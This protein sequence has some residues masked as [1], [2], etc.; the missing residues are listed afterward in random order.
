MAKKGSKSTGLL[1]YIFAALILVGFI[2]VIVGMFVGQVTMTASSKL[3]GGA[4]SK[5]YMLFDGDAWGVTEVAG[6]EIGVS[7]TFGI[8]SFI[9]A[10]IGAL[11]LVCDAVLNVFL[12][13]NFKIVRFVGIVLTFVGA[14]LV[15]VAGLVMANQCGEHLSVDLGNLAQVDYSAGAGVWLGFI[16]GLVAAIASGLSTVF[17]K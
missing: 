14:I 6:K 16:G 8:I 4:E 5:T 7:N 15:L 17:N 3:A 11:V 9:V 13:K 12:G 2:L 10:L 1:G